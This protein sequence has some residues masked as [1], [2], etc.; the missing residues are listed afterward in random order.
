M[1]GIFFIIFG[2]E[3]FF[4]PVFDGIKEK[5]NAITMLL[6]GG[7]FTHYGITGNI[8]FRKSRKNEK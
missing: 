8:I 2:G 5:L 3:L 6:M 4:F 7:I 1:L